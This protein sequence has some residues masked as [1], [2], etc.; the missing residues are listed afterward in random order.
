MTMEVKD[1]Y[2]VTKEYEVYSY[3]ELSDEAKERAVIDTVKEWV[4]CRAYEEDCKGSF[5][6]A[7]DKAEKMQ[8]PWFTGNYIYQDCRAEI[9]EE[10]NL[11]EFLKSGERFF[12]D[13]E[14]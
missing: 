2:K 5:E 4:E 7:C 3:E 1:M 13:E 11:Y 10:L 9:E 12:D 8:T 6:R 14:G